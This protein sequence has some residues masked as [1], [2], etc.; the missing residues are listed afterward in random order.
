MGLV[1]MAA[2]RGTDHWLYWVMMAYVLIMAFLFLFAMLWPARPPNA[3]PRTTGRE[4]DASA[5]GQR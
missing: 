1:L 5:E 2:G 3:A 4:D